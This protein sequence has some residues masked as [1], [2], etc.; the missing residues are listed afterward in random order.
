MS[1]RMSRAKGR[2]GEYE[3]RDLARTAGFEA[4]RV[5]LSGASQGF[6]GDVR[7]TDPAGKIQYV[8]VKIRA[9]SFKS[10]YKESFPV[11]I[12]LP[13]G[14]LIQITSNFRD[15]FY[16]PPSGTYF[17]SVAES[18]GTKRLKAIKPLLAGSDFLAIRDDR[19]AWLFIRYIR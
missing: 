1:G 16:G 11:C 19:Q 4:D 2:R 6:K 3:I 7:V 9:D 13:A 5:P 17:H 8:E 18:R 15:A 12:S 10:I 14:D